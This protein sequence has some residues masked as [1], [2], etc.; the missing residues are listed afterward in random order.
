MD[1]LS[2]ISKCSCHHDGL[3]LSLYFYYVEILKV[4]AKFQAAMVPCSKLWLIGLGN[5]FASKRL[6]VQTLLLSLEFV[7]Q[8][9]LDHDTITL[10]LW[11][12]NFSMIK[13]ILDVQNN[14]YV[15]YNLFLNIWDVSMY[16]L[17]FI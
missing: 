6:A 7:I 14:L 9:N 17:V 15:F 8:I 5:F 4:R 10:L 3:E 1:L 11:F 13:F 2:V 12:L 16:I